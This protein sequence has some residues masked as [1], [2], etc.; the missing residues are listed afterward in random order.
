MHRKSEPKETAKSEEYFEK[1]SIVKESKYKNYMR[2]ER[3][4]EKLRKDD[5]YKQWE[6]SL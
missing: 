2:E 4:K 6:V 3:V 5:P 1:E